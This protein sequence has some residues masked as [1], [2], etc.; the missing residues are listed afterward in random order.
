MKHVLVLVIVLAVF[1]PGGWV[2]FGE[3]AGGRAASQYELPL[4]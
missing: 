2:A 1:Q 4:G 3:E